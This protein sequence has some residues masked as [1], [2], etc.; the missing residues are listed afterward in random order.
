M[1][2]E[3]DLLNIL[4]EEFKPTKTIQLE[5]HIMKLRIF[6]EYEF[7]LRLTKIFGGRTLEYRTSIMLLLT[8]GLNCLCLCFFKQYT[9]FRDPETEP[10]SLGLEVADES[11]RRGPFD[12][13]PSHM[14]HGETF[15]E[16][17]NKEF[18]DQT[19]LLQETTDK[20]SPKVLSCTLFCPPKKGPETLFW[21]LCRKFV[22]HRIPQEEVSRWMWGN[23]T[24]G[25]MCENY[26]ESKLQ[27]FLLDCDHLKLKI[28]SSGDICYKLLGELGHTVPLE[29]TAKAKHWIR[30]RRYIATQNNLPCYKNLL[31][32]ISE[33]MEKS[34]SESEDE[35]FADLWGQ[36]HYLQ[37][38]MLG[39]HGPV[40]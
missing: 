19:F 9:G 36:Y 37:D 21:S 6:S 11:E 34:D 12:L 27:T 38:R 32:I 31:D 30:K 2:T 33:E 29:G 4:L 17:R 40:M 22:H 14:Q 35:V 20:G 23:S 26:S 3:T 1:E 28:F 39:Y 10:V 7:P 25:R 8:T 24:L 15:E 5:S 16:F 18:Y 13:R